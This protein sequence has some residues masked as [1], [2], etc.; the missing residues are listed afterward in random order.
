MD[1]YLVIFVIIIILSHIY[2]KHKDRFKVLEGNENKL[3]TVK[4]SN[5]SQRIINDI[6]AKKKEMNVL[7]KM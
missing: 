4:F 7:L 6:I 3:E 5:N 2:L 1:C